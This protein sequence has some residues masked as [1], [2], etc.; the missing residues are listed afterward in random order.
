M[1]YIGKVYVMDV[2]DHVVVSGYVIAAEL[3][4]E[5]P[6]ETYEF[7]ETYAGRGDNVAEEWLAHALHQHLLN[8][9]HPPRGGVATGGSTGDVHS[10]SGSGD[11]HPMRV[12]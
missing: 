7:S 2:L 10:I 4:N 3:D 1:R 8:R 5:E 6:E 11:S 9:N 12:R